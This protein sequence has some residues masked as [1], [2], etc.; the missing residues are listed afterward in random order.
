MDINKFTEKAQQALAASQSRAADAGQSQI[1]PEH[2]LDALL[3]QEGGIAPRIVERAGASPADLSAAVHKAIESMPRMSGPGAGSPPALSQR[4]AGVL[5]AAESEAR[6]IKDEFTS[7]EH[8]L[9][10][11]ASAG[12]SDSVV[13]LFAG[14]G[15]DREKL[16][17]ATQ[18]VRGNQRVTSQNPEGTYEAL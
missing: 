5:N 3:S 16:L 13:R 12:R 18:Q 17:S 9:L 15:L 2:L 8:L 6:K 7:V 1:E 10:A 14:A 11:L 4:L